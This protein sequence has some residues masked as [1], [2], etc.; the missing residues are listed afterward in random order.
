MEYKHF[1]HEHNLSMYQVQPGQQFRCSGCDKFCDKTIYACWQCNFFLHEHCGNATRYIRHPFHAP[2]HL[3]LCPYPTYP[4]NCFLC[5]ACGTTGTRFSYCCALC[6]VDLHVNCAFLPPKVS[7]KAHP[8][9]LILNLSNQ[10]GD[11]NDVNQMCK[12]CRKSLDSKHWSYECRICANYGVH[13]LCATTEMKM[14]LYQMDDGDC[15]DQGA[16]MAQQGAP[17]AQQAPIDGQVQVELTPEEAL[18]LLHIMGLKANVNA[19]SYV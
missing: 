18:A 11:H 6:E 8:H 9:E 7:H 12:I 2:H 13:T 16:P 4:S 15:S 1:S 5:N 3:I 17:M 14:G 10:T 19:A